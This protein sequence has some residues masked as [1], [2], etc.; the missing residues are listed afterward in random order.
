M[1]KR[2]WLASALT[3]TLLLPVGQSFAADL[4]PLPLELPPA[5]TKGTPSDLPAG[6][7]I[8]PMSETPRA[9]FMAPKG[10][11]N[12]ALKKKVTASL[13]KPYN[14]TYTQITDGQ[15]EAYDEQAV[16]MKKGTQ[17]VQVDLEKDYPISAIVIW[18]DHRS[19]VVFHDVV[20]QIADDAEFTKNVRT[21]FNN[22]FDN[23]SG[24]GLGKDKEY[25]EHR[26]GRLIDAKGVK[27]RYVRCYS[28]GSSQSAY[29]VYQEI[30]VY[31]LD[32]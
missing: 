16:E 20:V 23:S 25:F 22:D 15:K 5:S 2:I 11:K 8:E 6:P 26:E 12:V 17:W 21:L 4:A 31:A 10:V 27:A 18:H 7:N 32:Q 3:V 29:N 9:P 14:G 1:N 30:E 19:Y 24:L 28:K 13:D